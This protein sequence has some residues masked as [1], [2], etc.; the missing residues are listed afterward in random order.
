VA[1]GIAPRNSEGATETACDDD[2][3]PSTT[4]DSDKVSSNEEVMIHSAH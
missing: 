4:G 1:C 2:K 3:V